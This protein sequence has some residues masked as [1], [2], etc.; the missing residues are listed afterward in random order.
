MS[1]SL[2]AYGD[3]EVFYG[4][5]NIGLLRTEVE[6][7]LARDLADEPHHR[8]PGSRNGCEESSRRPITCSRKPPRRCGPASDSPPSIRS[9]R[10]ATWSSTG[11]TRNSPLLQP[12]GRQGQPGAPRRGDPPAC[13]GRGS[14]RRSGRRVADFL[15][16]ALR[17]QAAAVNRRLKQDMV[18]RDPNLKQQNLKQ[19]S[20]FDPE[21]PEEVIRLFEKYVNAKWPLRVYA[22]EP[23]IAQQNV[24]DAFGRRTQS[25]LEVAASAPAGPLK[26]LSGLASAGLTSERKAA[27]DETAI[28]LNPTMVGFGAGESTFGWVFYPQDPDQGAR[29]PTADRH[30]T[31]A[32][33]P[34]PGPDRQGAEHRAR[35]ARMHRADRDAQFRAQD[36]VHH[37]G[38][39]VP[40]QRG[41]RRSEV[42]PGEIVD[43]GSQA[44]GRRERPQPGQPSRASTAP[45]NT[46]LRSSGSTRSRA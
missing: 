7:Q 38:Q 43:P 42:R 33:R 30:R 27:E 17:I 34:V 45:R 6:H 29:R 11:T 3:T 9:R 39:L 15:G 23:V 5:T 18:D 13:G 14:R 12:N 22:I 24:A 40:H 35:P 37:R 36:R 2:V 21:A 31:P 4:P 8:M 25:A 44:G 46:R 16:F 28:R 1:F 26:V 32:E 20:F 10:S 41:R 19:T